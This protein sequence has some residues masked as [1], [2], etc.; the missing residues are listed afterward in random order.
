MNVRF[1]IVAGV[2]AVAAAA[3]LLRGGRPAAP[4]ST[5]AITAA[6]HPS[7]K[8]AP[9]LA[10]LSGAR[11]GNGTAR[12]RVVVYV[13][14]A[15]VRAGVYAL[16]AAARAIDALHAAGGVTLGAD[17]VA[18]NLAKPLV[19]GEELVFP[20]KGVERSDLPRARSGG[21]AAAPVKR[22]RAV[23][24]RRK[25]TPTVAGSEFPSGMP[26]EVIDLN[27]ADENALETLPGIGAALAA[28]IALVRQQSGPFASLDDL[29]DV[30][31]MTQSKL[32]AIA[33]YVTLH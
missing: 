6:A 2:V 27:V 11:A 15:V 9:A 12:V 14:G 4:S 8:S 31:G 26:T 23:K 16:P 28:R 33:P 21:A 18:V 10:A 32:D 3:A 22:K 24:R 1:P 5:L 13:A 30:N 17:T 20:L 29:L 25:R 7:P 19:D